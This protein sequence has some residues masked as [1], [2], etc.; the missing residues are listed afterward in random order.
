MSQ[1]MLLSNAKTKTSYLF[2]YN[3]YYENN[4]PRRTDVNK[5]RDRICDILFNAYPNDCQLICIWKILFGEFPA[6][7]KKGQ[8]QRYIERDTQ[9]YRMSDFV[10]KVAP[11]VYRFRM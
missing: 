10:D 11:K 5:I 2:D 7:L 1:E 9:H 4:M 6:P 8:V 3:E